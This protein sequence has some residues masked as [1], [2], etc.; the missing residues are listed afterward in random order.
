MTPKA[1][2]AIKRRHAELSERA[3]EAENPAD[4]L[5][6]AK[7]LLD[8]LRQAGKDV[9]LGDERD[10]LRTLATFWAGYIYEHSEAGTYPSAELAPYTGPPVKAPVRTMAGRPQ[11]FPVTPV[12]AAVGVLL[13]VLILLSTVNRASETRAEATAMAMVGVTA[14]AES[15][16]TDADGLSDLEEEKLGTDPHRKDSDG[17]GLTDMEEVEA[18]TDPMIADTDGDGLNDGE[19]RSWGSDPFVIDSDGDTIPDGVEVHERDTSPINKDTD[20]DGLNDNV[21][22]DPLI[23]AVQSTQAPQGIDVQLTNVVDGQEIQPEEILIGVYSNLRP[24]SSIHVI[25]EPASQG[26]RLY[27]VESSYRIPEGIPTGE[28]SIDPN[29]DERPELDLGERYNIRQVVA[30][31]DAGREALEGLLE[32][33]FASFDDLPPTIVIIRSVTTVNLGAFVKIDE[34]RLLYSVF[35]QDSNNNE[36]FS[37]RPDGSDARQLTFTHSVSEFEPSLSPDGRK[38]AFVGIERDQ[39][40]GLI[41]SLRLM[42]SNGQNPSVLL[43]EPGYRYESPDWSED[44]R[45]LVYDALVPD[46]AGGTWKLFLLDL[47]GDGMPILLEEGYLNSRYPAWL[48]GSEAFVFSANSPETGS[49]GIYRYDIKAGEASLL[50]D[51]PAPDSQPAVSR[52]GRKVAFV[53]TPDLT[54]QANFDLYV[55]DLETKEILHLAEH[56][57][58]DQFPAWHPDGTTIYFESFR[59]TGIQKVWA[60]GLD[61]SEAFQVT[62]DPGAN[63]GPMLG[64]MVA[65]MPRR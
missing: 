11:P 20:G 37:V 10:L 55:L 42:D 48:P 45:S 24:G 26:G 59:E 17:D 49:L 2:E 16:D 27:P 44:G 57:G 61:G 34:V 43:N 52:D 13:V 15:L 46:E 6:E 18:K 31:D 1:I 19:E 41:H 56:T 54:N 30:L 47:Q 33:G 3:K 5:P 8:A 51:S 62:S 65:F 64:P 60:A 35:L 50:Y 29:F 23:P 58:Q 39:S 32:T 25:L 21:D 7:D 14:A 9:P 4:L 53:S 40:G 36:I 38:I 63:V 22:P 12:L 28:W